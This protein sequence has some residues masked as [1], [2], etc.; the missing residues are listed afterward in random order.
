MRDRDADLTAF[1]RS[2]PLGEKIVVSGRLLAEISRNLPNRPIDVSTE[3]NK[4]TVTCGSSRF[5]T[6]HAP[7]CSDANS[8]ALDASTPNGSPRSMR[9]AARQVSSRAASASTEISA[10]GR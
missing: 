5:S 2:A 3:G 8:F 9:S 10:M 7:G 6:A 1:G 4:V